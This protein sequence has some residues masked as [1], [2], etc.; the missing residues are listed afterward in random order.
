MA[1]SLAVR[2]RP[3]R[4][5]DVA[6]QR[7]VV[8]VLRAAAGRRQPP[9]QI[10]LAGPSGLGK[11]TL[12]RIFA[13]ALFCTDPQP[14]GDACGTCTSCDAVTGPGGFHPD[15]IEMDAASTGGKDEIRELATRATLAPLQSP[16]KVYI[17]DEAHGLTSAGSQA[18]LKTLEEP[19]PHVLFIFATTDPDKL[20]AAIRG[21]CSIHEV[22]PPDGPAILANLRRVSDAEAWTLPESTLEAVVAASDPALGMR[23]TVMTLEKLSSVLV[24]GQ[25]PSDS[26]LEAILGAV[27]PA[28]LAHLTGAID[29]GDRPGSLLALADLSA[30]AGAAHLRR[31][32]KAHYRSEL[33]AAC[34]RRQGSEEAYR[35]YEL[36]VTAGTYPGALEVA[37]AQ[38]T[39]PTLSES[40]EHLSSLL[41]EA[42]GLLDQL[43]AVAETADEPSTP[44]ATE[45]WS[46]TWSP[47]TETPPHPEEP[48]TSE[49]LHTE[50]PH[51]E[52]PPHD[53]G[54]DAADDAP[55]APT[56]AVHGAEPPSSAPDSSLTP[57]SL[58]DSRVLPLANAVGRANARAGILLR[59]CS[60]AV[61]LGGALHVTVPARDAANCAALGLDALLVDAA[62]PGKVHLHQS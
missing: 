47:S 39:R 27:S 2:H 36:L 46:L 62:A 15:V 59:R 56:A 57:V 30:R 31:Q 42:Q 11:T 25:P 43:R 3:R 61:D 48:G 44:S 50:L 54:Q 14:D 19:P 37:V 38:M 23:G 12:A 24:P 41:E 5:A 60:F 40:A 13:A 34:R 28:R 55:P 8:A 10:L 45:P 22:L 16:W 9:Q 20:P 51:I 18:F 29:D 32:L 52:L 53:A 33:I 7:H 35:R 26:D 17:I 21:R 1:E 6:G 49:L 58:T 4:F